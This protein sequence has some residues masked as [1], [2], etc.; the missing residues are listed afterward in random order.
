MGFRVSRIAT[1]CDQRGLH[2]KI[3]QGGDPEAKKQ[4]LKFDLSPILSV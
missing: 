3:I 4:T 2:C 1:A